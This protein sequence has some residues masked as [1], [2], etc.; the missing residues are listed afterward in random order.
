MKV[1]VKVDLVSGV[2]FAVASSALF[3]AIPKQVPVLSQTRLTSRTFPYA[4]VAVMLAMSIR[5]I[6]S[7][8]VKLM[9]REP[10]HEKEF[11]LG[12]EGRAFLLFLLLVAYVALMPVVGAFVSSLLMGVAFLLY[13][14][15]TEWVRYLIVVISCVVVFW[16]FRVALGVQLP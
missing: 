12:D 14:R 15:T 8:T 2:F 4:I 7:E 1:R 10:V 5:L 3:F 11:N 6:V 9:R 16:A 13:F